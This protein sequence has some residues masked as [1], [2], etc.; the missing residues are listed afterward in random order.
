MK[1]KLVFI[2]LTLL[3]IIPAG[4]SAGM[5]KG[6]QYDTA[7]KYAD[8]DESPVVFFDPGSGDAKGYILYADLNASGENEM[9]IPYR[10]HKTDD[11][12]E[13]K[14]DIYRQTLSVD[15]VS[16]GKKFRGMMSVDLAYS[17]TPR[18][19]LTA[20]KI[21]EN[22]LPKVFLMVND[23]VDKKS[24]KMTL[25]Y[26][27]YDKKDKAREQK[28]FETDK[29]PWELIL[30]QFDPSIPTITEFD[31]NYEQNYGKYYIKPLDDPSKSVRVPPASMKKFED[32]LKDARH[33]IFFEYDE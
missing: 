30:Y 7:V 11:A 33:D 21:S 25:M 20:D 9:V 8:K 5:I 14:A 10:I 2:F 32:A 28:I 19:Y 26:S 13:D 24:K 18:V 4:L 31:I 29:M 3:I 23:G 15:V 6:S 22:E 1:N 12:I 16:A 17:Y 27:S